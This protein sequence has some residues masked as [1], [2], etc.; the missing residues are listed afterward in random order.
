MTSIIS[1]CVGVAVGVGVSVGE[2]VSVGV[3]VSVGA[4]VEMIAGVGWE[5]WAESATATAG[6]VATN[7]GISPVVVPW[8][9]ALTRSRR[10]DN[11]V[12]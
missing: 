10:R 1:G 8:L 12:H 3:G 9:Q 7:V 11:I 6:G 2:G 5:V 4:V